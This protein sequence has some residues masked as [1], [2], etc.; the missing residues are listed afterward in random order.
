[1]QQLN[2]PTSL[3]YRGRLVLSSLVLREV[4]NFMEGHGLVTNDLFSF[5]LF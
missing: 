5:G 4:P 2:L 1:M 3:R